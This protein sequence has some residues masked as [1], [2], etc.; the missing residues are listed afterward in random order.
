M[1]V[2]LKKEFVFNTG[3]VYQGSYMINQYHVTVKMMTSTDQGHEQNIA[4]DRV[5]FWI[6]DVLEN[7]VLISQD[8]EKIPAYMETGQRLIT[9]PAEPLDQ[10]IGIMLCCKLNAICED[11]LIITDVELKSSCGEDMIYLHSFDENIG[12][13]DD[14][15]WW[16]DPR[17][18]C[19]NLGQYRK[20]NVI[21]MSRTPEWK[22]IG[23]DWK[24]EQ[25]TNNTVVFADFK[26]ENETE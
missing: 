20:T 14:P 10:V 8:N 25:E 12:P 2:R 1:N 22:D 9:L 13:F 4:Y 5:R 24:Q 21:E 23:L 17:P 6:H 26:K 11:R 7:S 19:A 16:E 18:K 3:L 15:G